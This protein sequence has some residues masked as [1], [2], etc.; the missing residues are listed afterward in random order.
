ML[1]NLQEV[2]SLLSAAIRDHTVTQ[3]F[4]T[5]Q[6]NSNDL[7]MND[8]CYECSQDGDSLNSFDCVFFIKKL[9]AQTKLK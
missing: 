7:A 6:T 9:G 2:K 5:H 1:Q 4:I 3:F 8:L